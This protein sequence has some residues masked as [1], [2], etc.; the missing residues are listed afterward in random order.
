MLTFLQFAHRLQEKFL[1]GFDG[2]YGYL[3]IF[4][5]PTGTELR[6]CSSYHETPWDIT[7]FGKMCYYAGGILT[8]KHLFAFNRDISEHKQVSRKIPFKLLES[9]WL[10]LYM[11]YFPEK[12]TIALTT[13]SWSMSREMQMMSREANNTHLKRA[14]GHPAFR[15]FKI[16]DD[17]GK[18]IK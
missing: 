3:E 1:A 6:E 15:E 4:Q 2:N 17:E 18:A 12:N 5:N 14:A 10:P 11:Y 7:K 13:S 16:Y 9:N 8:S